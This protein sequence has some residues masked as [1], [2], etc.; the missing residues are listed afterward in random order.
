MT[1][2]VHEAIAIINDQIATADADARQARRDCNPSA[3]YEANER[4][5]WARRSRLL[6]LSTIALNDRQAPTHF[7]RER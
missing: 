3:L 6:A 7:E 2:L 1:A 5:R 4:A